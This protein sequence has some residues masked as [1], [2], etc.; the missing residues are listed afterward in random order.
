MCQI[1]F[2]YLIFYHYNQSQETTATPIHRQR[3]SNPTKID[4][5]KLD[6]M[7]D[8]VRESIDIFTDEDMYG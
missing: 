4:V 3:H 8:E 1:I 2:T 6:K 7:S 5:K